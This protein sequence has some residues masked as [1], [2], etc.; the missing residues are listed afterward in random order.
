[1]K[2]D[3]GLRAEGLDHERTKMVET[4]KTVKKAVKKTIETE[5]IPKKVVAKDEKKPTAKKA[6]VKK[7]A[8][9][10]VKKTAPKES[11]RIKGEKTP[12]EAIK[13]DKISQRAKKYRAAFEK[14]EKGKEYTLEEATSIIGQ[15]VTTR[16]DSSVEIHLN[17]NTDTKN[18]EH[19]LRGSVSLPAGLGKKKRIAVVC[20][21]DKEKE[22]KEAGADV[23][24]GKELI[25]KIVKGSIDFEVLVATPEM[26]PE[27]AKAGKILGPKGLMPNPKDNK[28][29]TDI[30][31]TFV[32]IKLGLAD[33]RADTFGIIHSVIGKAS[34]EPAKL[35]ENASAFLSAIHAAKPSSL[36]GKFIKSIYLTT[37]MGPSIKVKE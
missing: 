13:K 29:T 21:A 32:D 18:P 16:F 11:K 34:F 5:T 23:V 28:V 22:A 25:E 26:M 24:G 36:K 27:L 30:K 7:V 10:T 14:I 6:A 12:V 20:G 15:T 9:K 35:L 4:K 2:W 8:P 17:L 37:T 1:M 33:Y 31:N 3:L 19:A